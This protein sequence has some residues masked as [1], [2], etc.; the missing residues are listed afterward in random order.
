[1]D[2]ASHSYPSFSKKRKFFTLCLLKAKVR[3]ESFF[4]HVDRIVDRMLHSVREALVSLF[5][6]FHSLSRQTRTF[7]ASRRAV[8]PSWL[9][10]VELILT[11]VLKKRCELLESNVCVVLCVDSWSATRSAWV[12]PRV[13]AREE[14][15][16]DVVGSVYIMIFIAQSITQHKKGKK[17]EKK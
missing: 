13:E 17:Y 2:E 8:A 9:F 3:L 7:P 16:K 12:S 5:F 14:V 11:F 1:M 4:L 10:Y 6:F 15:E